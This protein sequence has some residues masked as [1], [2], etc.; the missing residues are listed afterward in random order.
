VGPYTTWFNL[1]L[2][3]FERDMKALI[4]VSILFAVLKIGLLA[5]RCGASL[6]DIACP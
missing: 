6:T 3:R 2:N 1:N 5:T 4:G